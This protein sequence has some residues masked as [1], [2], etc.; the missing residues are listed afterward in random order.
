M[1]ISRL[2]HRS[3]LRHL[4]RPWSPELNQMVR[5]HVLHLRHL[6][7]HHVC[8]QMWLLVNQQPMDQAHLLGV[9]V[10]K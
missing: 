10:V 9:N 1:K 8:M 6:H 3:V 2:G 4:V 5:G 7:E